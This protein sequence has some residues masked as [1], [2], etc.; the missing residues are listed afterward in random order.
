MESVVT[1]LK[2]I[3]RKFPAIWIGLFFTLATVCVFAE[4]QQ[5]LRLLV[6]EGYAPEAQREQFRQYI[7]D[8]SVLT[9]I[10]GKII[11]TKYLRR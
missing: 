8:A 5:V 11:L 10:Y 9:N 3:A 2:Y 4:N 6:W 7:Y 1:M